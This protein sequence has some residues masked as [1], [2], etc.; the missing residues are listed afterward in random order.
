MPVP[1]APFPCSSWWWWKG[2]E[3]GGGGKKGPLDWPRWSGTGVKLFVLW[4]VQGGGRLR[5][6][7]DAK[8]QALRPQPGQRPGRTAPG[9]PRQ[10]P[11]QQTRGPA[12]S[13]SVNDSDSQTHCHLDT[14]APQIEPAGLTGIPFLPP[15]SSLSGLVTPQPGGPGKVWASDFPGKTCPAT[16]EPQARPRCGGCKPLVMAASGCAPRPVRVWEAS[17]PVSCATPRPQEGQR[18]RCEA[19]DGPT[20]S[21]HPPHPYSGL[22]NWSRFEVWT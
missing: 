1:R 13:P 21:P 10:A 15:H 9:P 3:G 2:V 4:T 16:S 20:R 11:A 8:A 5:G 12:L 19:G 6:K 14:I 7:Q 22:Q 18:A 17:F